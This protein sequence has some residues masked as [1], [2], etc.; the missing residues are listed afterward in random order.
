MPHLDLRGGVVSYTTLFMNTHTRLAAWL[1]QTS[2][3]RAEFARRCEY[4][5][6]NLSKLLNGAIKP[7]LEMAFRIERATDGVIPASEWVEAA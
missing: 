2:T 7:T 4:D 6:S 5:P 1:E 3:S